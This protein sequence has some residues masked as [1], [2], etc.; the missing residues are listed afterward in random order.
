MKV[1]LLAD[2]GSTFTKMSAVDLEG[3][4]IAHAQAATTVRQGIHVGL[5]EAEA[6]VLQEAQLAPNQVELRLSSSSAAGGLR[7]I[8]VG[9]VP[10]LTAEAARLAAL[11]AGS[12]VVK[13]YAYK[14]TAGDIEEVE[15]IAP[16]ILLLAGGA[17]GGDTEHV[18]H[19]AETLC[20]GVWR[21]P[22]VYAG[23]RAVSIEVKKMLDEQGFEV[24]A[25]K[26]VMPK[27]G[28]LAVE[29]SRAAI[30][31]IFFT[32]IVQNKGYDRAKAWASS[33]IMPTP[34]AVQ[35]AVALSAELFQSKALL[36]FDV[37]GATTDVY[38][39][40]GNTVREKAYLHGI[41]AP[42]EM[43][44][45]EGDLGVRVSLAALLQIVSEEACARHSLDVDNLK[46]CL[47]DVECVPSISLPECTDTALA[48]ICVETAAIRHA[49]T[50][51]LLP[52]PFGYTGIQ[53]GKDLGPA[54]IIL[55]T[56]GLLSRL[57]E[58]DKVLKSALASPTHPLSLLPHAAKV[59]RD[60]QY[61]FYAAGLLSD[62]HK[63]VAQRLI[64]DSLS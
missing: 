46:S 45:V 51:E 54:D 6:L 38:S 29:E 26:N 43:R 2:I 53:R 30:R 59:Y 34:A 19:N 58:Y 49:G 8:T 5:L 3:G 21:G 31:Q 61:V 25:V 16:D 12:R 64:E 42:Y 7:M 14:L 18:L 27:L 63:G 56:G 33:T 62:I 50:L 36:A 13:V 41:P 39:M 4:L 22:V 1:A 35:R 52:T 9:L 37:G 48:A 10:E 23:N 28:T 17:D 20:K 15:S 24:V 57:P 47:S 60:K 11:G 40:G 32:R 55:G 44:T